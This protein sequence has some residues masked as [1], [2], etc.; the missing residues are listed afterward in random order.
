MNVWLAGVESCMRKK[1][2]VEGTEEAGDKW[3]E[4]HQKSPDRYSRAGFS[5]PALF[6][7][8][9]GKFFC[10]GWGCLVHNRVMSSGPDHHI[11]DASYA[12]HQSANLKYPQGKSASY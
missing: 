2:G 4:V 7:V 11:L 10:W 5:I 12:P 1:H 9:A 3:I 8:V 6:M